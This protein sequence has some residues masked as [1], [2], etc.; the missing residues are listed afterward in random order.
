MSLGETSWW[1]LF[2]SWMLLGAYFDL[3]ARRIPNALVVMAIA[4]QVCLL[5][6]S[7]WAGVSLPGASGWSAALIGFL[8]GFSSLIFWI[9][10]LMGGGDV[11][12][13]AALGFW[14]GIGPMLPILLFGTLAA[15]VHALCQLTYRYQYGQVLFDRQAGKGCPY[16]G[17]LALS[18]VS[19]AL[20]QLSSRSC[21]SF[22]SRFCTP[23]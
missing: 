1:W 15:L 19:L 5:V 17:Y 20:M 3:R 4:I 12:F 11:K 13:L 9:L 21:L 16:A 14:V 8:V 7:T 23:F 18:A 2:I 10:R 6:Y 22:F